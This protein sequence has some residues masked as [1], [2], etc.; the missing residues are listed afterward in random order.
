MA[1]VAQYNHWNFR[2]LT[3]R[4]NEVLALLASWVHSI[5]GDRTVAEFY[6]GRAVDVARRK[7]DH[8][9]HHILAI[10]QTD[11]AEHAM[12]VEETLI[13]VFYAHRKNSNDAADA[14][15]AVST[16]FVNYVYVAVWW[17]R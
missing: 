1:N 6:I 13:D 10:Y 16:E 5:A 3:G 7:S 12:Q 17:S 15:G 9:A 11:S 8:G 2:A 14:R 4:P